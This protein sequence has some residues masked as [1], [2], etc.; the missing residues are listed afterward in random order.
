VW[1]ILA[2]TVALETGTVWPIIA[3]H[4][5]LNFLLDFLIHREF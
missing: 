4:W 3:V 5:V 1:G 2:G